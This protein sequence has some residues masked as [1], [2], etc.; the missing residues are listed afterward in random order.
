MEE[1]KDMI[2]KSSGSVENIFIIKLDV[3]SREMVSSVASECIKKFGS[4]DILINNAGIV[5]GK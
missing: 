4:V 1:T 5:L 2:K 3:S